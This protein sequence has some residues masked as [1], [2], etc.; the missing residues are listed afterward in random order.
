MEFYHVLNRG[1]DKRAIFLNEKDYLR[2]T[3]NLFEFNN[4]EKINNNFYTFQKVESNVIGYHNR[5]RKLLVDIHLFCLMQ[6]HYHLLLSSRTKDGIPRFMH[7]L[8]M[9]YARYFNEKYKRSGALFEGKYKS[10]LIEKEAHFFHLPY[11]IHFNPLDFKFP[12]WRNNDLRDYK[13][14]KKFL[15]SYRWSSH[16]DYSGKKNFSSVTQR[17]FLLEVFGGIDKY[18]KNIGQ[19]LR[20]MELIHFKDITLE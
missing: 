5:P 7:K 11:Y 3:H 16:L 12:E 10:V 19:S 15:D 13:K 14:A 4:Q 8:N 2:F 1:V 20:S 9:G 6:N 18:K 17:E